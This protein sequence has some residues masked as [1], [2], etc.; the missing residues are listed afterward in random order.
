MSDRPRTI[1]NIQ[2]LRGVA[3]LMVV[4]CHAVYSTWKIDPDFSLG[5]HL[6]DF[7]PVGVD[8]FFVISG[9]I[10]AHTA[11]LQGRK[12]PLDFVRQRVWRVVPLYALL[13]LPWIAI[14]AAAGPLDGGRLL[15][16][17]TLWPV[18][19]TVKT[20]YLTVGWTLS[21]EMLFY[22][23]AALCLW[24]PR[25]STIVGLLAVYGL[26]WAGACWS[27]AP[28]LVYLGNPIIVEFLLGV[29]IALMVQ[30]QNA[31]LGAIALGLGLLVLLA[32]LIGGYGQIHNAYGVLDGT[33]SLSRLVRW[34]LPCACIV[35]GAVLMPDW[36][37]A[38]LARPLLLL[39]AASYAIY[40]IHPLV[41]LG[42]R[43]M[44]NAPGLTPPGAMV[45]WIGLL[46]SAASGVL[47]HRYLERPPAAAGRPRPVAATGRRLAVELGHDPLDAP[48]LAFL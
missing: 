38:R 3:A 42:L 12:H 20:P 5:R 29:G 10:I 46:A 26:C 34:G 39:G 48:A 19:D 23:A 2:I 16:S 31:V 25:R 1:A 47:A 43:T 9:F 6:D 33:I 28:L 40:L 14:A 17:L 35:L 41:L 22:A 18:S 37:P 8:L 30:R 45:F 21:F 44:L 4:A 27:A 7:G 13:G 11:F 24:R 32:T 36:L 15:A